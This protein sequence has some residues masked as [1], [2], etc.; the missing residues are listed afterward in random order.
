MSTAALARE[1]TEVLLGL[2]AAM[3]TL[4]RQID[5]WILTMQGEEERRLRIRAL[6][7]IIGLYGDRLPARERQDAHNHLEA[8]LHLSDFMM[9]SSVGYREKLQQQ[10]KA[11]V[12]L[13][14]AQLAE[15]KARFNR[16]LEGFH[17]R[18]EG[19]GAGGAA[20][21]LIHVQEEERKRISRE[22]HDGPAQKLATLTMR[23]DF[24]F[25]LLEQPAAL[26]TELMSLKA[27]LMAC[28]QEIRRF[29]FDLRPMAIDDLGLI[30]TL[31][32]FISGCKSRTNASIHLTIEGAR[33]SLPPERELA[34][35]RVIQEA[36]NNAIRHAEARSIQIHLAFEEEPRSLV[37]V[38]KDDG[39]GFNVPD[40][41]KVYASLKRLG[42]VSMEE[43]IR[44][45]GGTFDLVSTPGGGTVVSFRIPR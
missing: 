29:I 37:G 4:A 33:S 27:G 10:V 17:G 8:L 19:E 22:I 45:A 30:P 6:N 14:Q 7:T 35:F 2:E 26:K 12:A 16:L 13:I 41:R 42:L 44:L 38:V 9:F 36:V 25:D 20:A 43:R 15:A 32:Q 21:D 31:E 11:Q 3:A 34:V 5:D 28:V 40:L 18:A 1:M 23:L 39:Q 24:A